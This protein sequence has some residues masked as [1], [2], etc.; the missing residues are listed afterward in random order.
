MNIIKYLQLPFRFD[1]GAMYREVQDL[2]DAAWKMHYNTAHYQGNWSVL[3][4]RAPGGDPQNTIAVH[5]TANGLL[6]YADTPLM[7]ACP[8]IAAALDTLHCPKTSV[9]L[10][11]LQAGAVIHKHA[12]H[13]MAFE[14]GEVRLHIPV[15]TNPMVQFFVDDELVPMAEGECWYLNL[16]LPHNVNNHGTT[17]RIHLVADCM[18]NDWVR[19]LFGRD[20]LPVKVMTEQ[21]AAKGYTADQYARIIEE[22]RRQNTPASNALADT[23]RNTL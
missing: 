1:A 8:G 9:R 17:D 22:L 12:D 18:V 4:L 14:Q 7:A 21:D 11:K 3:P 23:F 20:D 6:S 15:V 10:M 16:Q 5:A 19:A 13:D 2:L